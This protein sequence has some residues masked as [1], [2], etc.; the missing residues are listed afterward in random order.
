MRIEKRTIV[1][2]IAMF[3]FFLFFGLN[4]IL[5]ELIINNKVYNIIA[6]IF[7]CLIIVGGLIWFFLTKKDD[8]VVADNSFLNQTKITLYIV[9]GALVLGIVSGFVS[10]GSNI[11]K[12]MLVIS[13]GI[14]GITSLY[15]IYISIKAFI[16]SDSDE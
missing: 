11:Q 15:G 4:Y 14:M 16:S 12:Y 9:A 7:L 13:G 2:Q 3:T 1:M 10:S 5:K 8:I 6:L